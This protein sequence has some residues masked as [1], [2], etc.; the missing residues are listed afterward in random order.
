MR[1]KREQG[2][3]KMKL[4][5]EIVKALQGCIEEG[6][7]SVSDFAKFANVSGNTITKYLRRETDSIKEDTWKK[8]HPLIKNYLPK[9][10]KSDVHKKPLELTSDE[11]ILLDAFADLAPDVQRQK[12]MEI[13]DL[14]KKFNRR[15]AEK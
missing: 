6:F 2:R 5:D 8:I 3:F 1:I 13:I 11:K 9:K 15:K 4:T 7:E 12:L 10:K 14:A